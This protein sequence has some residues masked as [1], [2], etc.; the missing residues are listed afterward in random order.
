MKAQITKTNKYWRL[1]Y[2]RPTNSGL[3]AETKHYL[4]FDGALHEW[5]RI[6]RTIER[7]IKAN[8]KLRLINPHLLSSIDQHFISKLLSTGCKD[9][10][11]RQYGYLT[12]I[13][14]RQQSN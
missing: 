14:E 11:Q 12:G 4:F 1:I 3:A 2:Y 6:R 8:Q 13:L 5:N 10:T 9:I 7:D